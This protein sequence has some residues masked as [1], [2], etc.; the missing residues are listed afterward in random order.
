M[1]SNL[2]EVAEWSNA[3]DSKSTLGQPNVGSNPTLSVFWVS[4]CEWWTPERAD[5]RQP[6]PEVRKLR[7]V[8]V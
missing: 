2:G 7:L 6:W 4:F 3:V 5:E 1:S 8:G